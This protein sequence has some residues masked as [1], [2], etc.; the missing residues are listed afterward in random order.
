MSDHFK[1]R[2]V[3]TILVGCA[4][5]LTVLGVSQAVETS[6][7]STD[8][9]NATSGSL[10]AAANVLP[11]A[12]EAWCDTYKNGTH[13]L[14]DNY[15]SQVSLTH[16]N[17]AFNYRMYVLYDGSVAQTQANKDTS[18][19]S[20][21]TRIY[22]DGVSGNTV[23]RR[24][25]KN[26]YVRIYAVNRI[27]GEMSADWIG[28][29]LHQ[30]TVYRVNCSGSATS[31]TGLPPGVTS[32][33]EMVNF[34]RGAPTTAESTTAAPTTTSTP[35]TTEST[36]AAPPTTSTPTTTESATTESTTTELT[37]TLSTTAAPTTTTAQPRP[38]ASTIDLGDGLSAKLIDGNLVIL[39]AGLEQCSASVSGAEK[40]A[41]HGDGRIAVGGSDDGVRYVDTANC[42][43]S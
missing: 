3:R 20:V 25:N 23:G 40:I 21:G 42:A 39:A 26:Y 27:S 18:G 43:I 31:G 5:A 33:S 8:T 29:T 34:D 16:I 28:W 7:A 4:A 24:T 19:L 41:D 17:Q 2:P 38:A 14:L 35:T 9:V 36:T 15:D 22:F 30:P 6:A 32:A 11:R 13:A 10:S 12:T 37:T 1:R